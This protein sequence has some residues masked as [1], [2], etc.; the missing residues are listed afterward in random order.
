LGESGALKAAEVLR[1]TGRLA[2]FWNVYQSSPEMTE[3][4][5]TV[6]RKVLPEAPIYD[7]IMVALDAY[8]AFFD[9]RVTPPQRG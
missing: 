2:V 6:Y 5:R 4:F 3:A 7:R 1:P 9:R 8:S